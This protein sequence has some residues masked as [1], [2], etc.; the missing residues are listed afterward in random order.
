M[1]EIGDVPLHAILG[2]S[3]AGDLVHFHFGLFRLGLSLHY[4]QLRIGLSD[5]G[6][7][8]RNDE[9]VLFLHLWRRHL[10]PPVGY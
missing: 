4:L 9:I 3:E 5:F 2:R 8:L 7:E 1:L 10:T 6:V